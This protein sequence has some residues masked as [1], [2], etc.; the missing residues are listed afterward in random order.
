MTEEER[1]QTKKE[2]DKHFGEIREVLMSLTRIFKDNRNFSARFVH[3]RLKDLADMIIIYLDQV[4]DAI[5]NGDLKTSKVSF[6]LTDE[7]ELYQKVAEFSSLVIHGM[8]GRING[9]LSQLTMKP[10]TALDRIIKDRLEQRVRSQH[11]LLKEFYSYVQFY[12]IENRQAV[13][14]LKE[15][16]S[17]APKHYQH[18]LGEDN[19][20]L[21]QE[22]LELRKMIFYL[23]INNKDKKLIKNIMVWMLLLFIC[24]IYYR[25]FMKLKILGYLRFVKTYAR[26]CQKKLQ[27]CL[28]N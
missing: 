20:R 6:M 23:M 10:K 7:T 21:E 3:E 9:E 26:E 11:M 25:W 28:V 12:G 8:V 22:N 15:L 14:M 18:K 17:F 2:L 1:Q 27:L 24:I 4:T 16:E 19:N 5:E 13:E